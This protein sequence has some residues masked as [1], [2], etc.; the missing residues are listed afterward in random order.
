MFVE[1][2][3]YHNQVISDQRTRRERKQ[4]AG[5]LFTSRNRDS[6]IVVLLLDIIPAIVLS[7]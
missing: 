4:L 6:V 3:H 5:V 2:L 7:P 1:V